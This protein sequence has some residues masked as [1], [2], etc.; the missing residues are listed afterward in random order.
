MTFLLRCPNC[1]E[2]SV[3]DFRFGGETLTRPGKDA[4]QSERT[5]YYYFRKNEEG[6]QREWWYH[7]YGCR[8]WF[9]AVRDTRN[10]E[11]VR[12]FWPEEA[13][14]ASEG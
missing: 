9:F 11:V 12:T 8:H 13:E 2:R 10:N 5:H 14:Q 7:K 4:S 3:L 6:V 1:G